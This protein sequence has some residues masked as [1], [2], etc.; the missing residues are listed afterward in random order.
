MGCNASENDT[1]ASSTNRTNMQA[2]K[3]MML[4]RGVTNNFSAKDFN[5]L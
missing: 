3:L 2:N 1:A 5:R 4:R